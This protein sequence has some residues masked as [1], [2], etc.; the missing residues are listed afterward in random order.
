MADEIKLAMAAVLLGVIGCGG[1]GHSVAR[2]AGLHLTGRDG[3]PGDASVELYR[4]L[5][6]HLER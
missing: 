1:G 2:D 4:R 3:A 6:S 5:R